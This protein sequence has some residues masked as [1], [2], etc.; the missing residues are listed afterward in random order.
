M[1]S[2]GKCCEAPANPSRWCRT[3]KPGFEH[4]ANMT[5]TSHGNW[6][7]PSRT[8]FT[9]WT[10]SEGWEKRLLIWPR[11]GV[12]TDGVGSL[13]MAYLGKVS[14]EIENMIHVC[15]AATLLTEFYDP[16]LDQMREIPFDAAARMIGK[17]NDDTEESM[18]MTF[19]TCRRRAVTREDCETRMIR[20]YCEHPAISLHQFGLI[21]RSI[22]VP[23]DLKPID[24][25]LRT[26]IFESLLMLFNLDEPC[27]RGD[28]QKAWKEAR[29]IQWQKK[30]EGFNLANYLFPPK[31][32]CCDPRDE[33][34]DHRVNR[35]PPANKA[36]AWHKGGRIKA[37]GHVDF[38]QEPELQ[39]AANLAAQERTLLETRASP[40]QFDRLPPPPPPGPPPPV[41][42]PPGPPPTVSQCLA[43]PFY[44]ST[45]LPPDSDSSYPF[46]NVEV[47]S[48]I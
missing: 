45:M 39:K 19:P 29:H 44:G 11:D 40:M 15:K 27:P 32:Q 48:R 46:P 6:Y 23:Q 9:K 22:I 3:A 20:P 30:T 21:Y 18:V 31:V 13:N 5:S 16:V 25:N 10:G 37:R 2:C 41:Q 24:V 38:T 36:K 12:V 7:C 1:Y 35:E 8:C 14:T 47:V 17:I 33:V 4:E 42:P 28:L 34:H 43:S 26:T